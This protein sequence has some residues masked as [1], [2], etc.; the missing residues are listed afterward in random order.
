[1]GR[2]LLDEA[3]KKYGRLTVIRAERNARGVM[4]WRCLC[5]CGSTPLVDGTALRTGQSSCRKCSKARLR[6]GHAPKSSR[7]GSK[8]FRAWRSMRQRCYQETQHNYHRYGGRGIRVCERWL[9]CFE[10]FLADM[11]TAPS[12]CHS[13]DRIDNDGDYEPGNC[14]WATSRE[15]QR[16]R[17]NS[18]L[19]T[20][21]GVTQTMAQWAD[22][23]GLS[24]AAI[25]CRLRRGRTVEE[26][27]RTK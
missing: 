13:I 16:N 3:N 22:Q 5:E 1:M 20:F 25:K 11:G 18:R 6:H 8:E 2:P 7:G 17:C 21:G 23:T 19:L 4:K 27:L 14:R 26:A 24:Y 12:P 15:Q 9:E 10:N